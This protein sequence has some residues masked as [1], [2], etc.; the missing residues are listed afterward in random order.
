MVC[1]CL[2]VWAV[3]HSIQ[4]WRR[5][6]Y[7][8]H[9]IHPWI[10][11][12]IIFPSL[13]QN[14][15]LLSLSCNVDLHRCVPLVGMILFY[16]CCTSSL[17]VCAEVMDV[18]SS[19][20]MQKWTLRRGNEA[21]KLL[22]RTVFNFLRWCSHQSETCSFWSIYIWLLDQRRRLWFF[23]R[24]SSVLHLNSHVYLSV[25][26]SCLVTVKIDL[27]LPQNW[28]WFQKHTQKKHFFSLW[29]ACLSHNDAGTVLKYFHSLICMW[30]P[31]QISQ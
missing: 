29:S 1:G 9:K 28:A 12:W 22:F 25:C 2:R 11:G 17:L 7:R 8:H 13:V 5:D 18:S 24:A 14:S 23:I 16:L 27:F 20:G 19:T 21:S 26:V 10:D 31:A 30:P 6:T 15:F 3:V 4:T